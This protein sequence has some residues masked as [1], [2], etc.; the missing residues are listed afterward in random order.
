MAEAGEHSGEGCHGVWGS[1]GRDG[2]FWNQT[3]A[4]VAHQECTKL[5]TLK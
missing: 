3:V 1:T 2:M 4:K 5:S